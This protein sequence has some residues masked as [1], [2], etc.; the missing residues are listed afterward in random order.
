MT[1]KNQV[2]NAHESKT[3]TWVRYI[4]STVHNIV[5]D[6]DFSIMNKFEVTLLWIEYLKD[7]RIGS[8]CLTR[9]G[10]DTIPLITEIDVAESMVAVRVSTGVVVAEGYSTLSR[11]LHQAV[12]E[13]GFP[14]L[15][16]ALSAVDRAYTDAG[17]RF[18]RDAFRT[19]MAIATKTAAP[20][21][22]MYRAAKRV[23]D[24]IPEIS[25]I[26]AGCERS[27]VGTLTLRLGWKQ[28]DAHISW[29]RV[30]EIPLT[31]IYP[32]TVVELTKSNNERTIA[33]AAD[34]LSVLDDAI[35]SEPFMSWL[36]QHTLGTA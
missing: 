31:Q 2:I 14:A 4:K 32:T 6:Y 16:Q 21:Q 19:A 8:V 22:D 33:G 10:I 30:C 28:E 1:Q 24:G 35:N 18:D 17:I 26:I 20:W 11:L 15:A 25:N 27:D 36:A 29:F 5:S 7:R 3:D 34:F 12:M 23:I 9:S 13:Q